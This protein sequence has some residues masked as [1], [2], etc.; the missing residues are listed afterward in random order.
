MQ[1]QSKLI[2]IKIDLKYGI[3]KYIIG[4]IFQSS[5]PMNQDIICRMAS[6]SPFHFNFSLISQTM[7]DCSFRQQPQEITIA[8]SVQEY[9]KCVIEK[10]F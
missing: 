8:F 1:L 5:K 6:V 2:K 3:K 9:Q 10:M 7:L 4:D